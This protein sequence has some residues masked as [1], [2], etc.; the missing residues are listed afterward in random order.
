VKKN[1]LFKTLQVLLITILIVSCKSEVKE[2]NPTAKKKPPI[3]VDAFVV[4][5]KSLSQDIEVPGSLIPFEETEIQ[6]ETSGRVTEILFNEGTSISKGAVLVKLFDGDL[7]AQLNKLNIQL[8]VAEQTLERY[9]ALLKINGVSQQEYDQYK[10]S[11]NSL[12]ADK[13]ILQ[14]N[15]EKNRVRA[16]FSG[17][18]GLRNISLGAYINSQSIITTIRQVNPLKLDFSVP[19]KYGSILKVGDKVFFTLENEN[20]NYKATIIATENN[21]AIDSRSLR[22]KAR[23]DV[24]NPKLIAGSFVKV[25]CNLGNNNAAI[26]IPSQ[27]VIPKSRNKQVLIYKNGSAAVQV[28]KTGIRDSSMVEITSGLKVGDTILTTGLLSLKPG[29]PVKLNKIKN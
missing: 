13:Q 3:K 15:I 1:I 5:A 26:M 2:E 4:V 11:V 14:T 29:S 6:P 9:D 20:K 7:I 22:I 18:V 28:V 12:Q 21:I 19:E 23:V 8:K 16:P 17:K 24:T 10:L 25:S 27:A